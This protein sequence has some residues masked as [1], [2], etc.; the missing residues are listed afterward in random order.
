MEREYIKD[1]Y[2]R[3][4]GYMERMD[5]GDEIAHL[6]SGKIVA[7]YNAADN[8]TRDYYGRIISRSNVAVASIFKEKE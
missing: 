2:G 1:Y 6:A 5:N 3:I 8:T 7:R 4:L